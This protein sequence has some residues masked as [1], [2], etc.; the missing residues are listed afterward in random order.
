[1]KT[2]KAGTVLKDSVLAFLY[3]Q[4]VIL[5]ILSNPIQASVPIR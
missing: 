3:E 2:F 1:V 5:P 4:Q